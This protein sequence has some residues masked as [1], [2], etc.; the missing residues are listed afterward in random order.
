MTSL[1]W[2]ILVLHTFCVINNLRLRAYKIL[3][4]THENFTYYDHINKLEINFRSDVA[5]IKT[6]IALKEFQKITLSYLRQFSSFLPT[7]K[8]LQSVI[9]RVGSKRLQ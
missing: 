8:Y 9:L 4:I 3:A 1:D 6:R 2:D 5:H 7:M